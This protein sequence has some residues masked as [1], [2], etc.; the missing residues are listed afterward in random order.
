MSFAIFNA[1]CFDSLDAARLQPPIEPPAPAGATLDHFAGRRRSAAVGRRFW[2]FVASNWPGFDLIER[3]R[4]VRMF[5]RFRADWS[6]DALSAV[7]RAFYDGLP[8]SSPPIAARTA[9]SWRSAP[10]SRCRSTA[11]AVRRRGRRVFALAAAKRD[12]A[13]AFAADGEVVMFPT[14]RVDLRARR[15]VE[16]VN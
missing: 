3:A 16:V 13:L 8:A 10:P 1:D 7:D 11:R 6:R 4:A 9:P 2:R 5:A 15:L 12:V 14:P